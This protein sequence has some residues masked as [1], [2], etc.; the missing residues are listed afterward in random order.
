MVRRAIKE[1][2]YMRISITVSLGEQKLC[3]AT[4]NRT[5]SLYKLIYSFYLHSAHNLI[6][7]NIILFS[8]LLQQ[9]IFQ[10]KLRIQCKWCNIA[11]QMSNH[12]LDFN[13]ALNWNKCC[14]FVAVYLFFFLL[15]ELQIAAKWTIFASLHKYEMCVCTRLKLDSN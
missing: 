15:N 2:T 13:D 5:R 10:S 1:H 8:L 7:R 3:T 9:Q 11:F 14:C 4:Q 6:F 12:T